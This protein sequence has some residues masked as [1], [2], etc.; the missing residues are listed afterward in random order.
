MPRFIRLMPLAALTLLAATLSACAPKPAPPAPAATTSA[1]ATDDAEIARNFP[2]GQYEATSLRD[3]TV[4]VPND[5][6]IFAVGGTPQQVAAVLLGAGLPTDTIRLSLDSL[7]VR[8]GGHV[9][10]F[11]TGAGINYGEGL[12]RL[13]RNMLAIGIKPADVTDIFISHAH[14]DHVGGLV[15]EK[16]AAVFTAASIHVS[17]PEWDF[18]KSL[19]AKSARDVGII[20][21]EALMAA[22]KPK[23]R[24]FAPGTQLLPGLVKAV[25][26]KGHTPGHSGYLIGEGQGS[27]LYIGDVLHHSVIS[28]QKPEWE[29][30]FDSDRQAGVT[31]RKALLERTAADGQRVYAAH[32]PYPGIGK[33]VKGAS[34]Y[35]WAAE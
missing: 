14:G 2:I 19:D 31:T 27:V 34:G 30:G 13:A 22:M 15:D 26:F 3:G 20:Q 28:V 17:A 35:Q 16:G 29:N 7:L 32:F 10:L 4:D 11:D 24:T 6:K 18:L 1:P 21:Y 12:G 33:F 25:E 8:G 23:V 5:N 9:M